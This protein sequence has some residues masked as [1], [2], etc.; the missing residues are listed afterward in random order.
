[1]KTKGD[2][3]IKR[4]VILTVVILT[5]SLLST[6]CGSSTVSK[7][8]EAGMNACAELGALDQLLQADNT[9]VDY[10]K[11]VTYIADNAQEASSLNQ[12]KYSQLALLATIFQ[13]SVKSGNER[14]MLDLVA[15]E[16]ECSNLGMWA[17]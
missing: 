12:S 4:S 8:F 15:L 14:L 1:M 13:D 7:D 11:M 6:G 10:Q 9:E 17:N 5:S 2:M 16:G 3:K